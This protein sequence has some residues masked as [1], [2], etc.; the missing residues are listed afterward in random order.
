M[1]INGLNVKKCMF[2]GEQVWPTAYVGVLYG[3]FVTASTYS[4]TTVPAAGGYADVTW[5]LRIER[6]DGTVVDTVD[7]TSSVSVTI[8]DT[9]NFS[10][11]YN[12]TRQKYEWKANDRGSNGYGTSGSAIPQSADAR[13]CTI[14]ASITNYQYNNV[15]VSAAT[16]PQNPT[17]MRQNA[18]KVE[19]QSTYYGT[20]SITLDAYKTS[21]SAAPAYESSTYIHVTVNQYDRYQFYDDGNGSKVYGLRYTREILEAYKTNSFN[22]T[23]DSWVTISDKTTTRAKVTVSGRGHD[24]GDAR[25]STITATLSGTNVSNDINIYQQANKKSEKSRVL[26]SYSVLISKTAS[27]SGASSIANFAQGG[28]YIY[29]VGGQATYTITYEWPSRDADTT[30]PLTASQNPTSASTDPNVGSGNIDIANRRINI[31]AN[32]TDQ[33]KNYSV[34][35]KFTYGGVTKQSECT[36]NQAGIVYT[37]GTPQVSFGYDTI[38]ASGGNVFPTINFSQTRTWSGGTAT[39]VTGSLSGGATSGTA[40]DG[41][42]FSIKSIT[43][44]NVNPGSLR[45][46][47]GRVSIESRGTERQQNPTTRNAATNIKITITSHSNDGVNATGVS[48]VQAANTWQ[49]TAAYTTCS[50]LN[51]AFSPSTLDYAGSTVVG[52]LATAGGNDVTER[53][54]YASGEHEGGVST[55]YSGRSV[56]LK[57]LSVNGTSQSD[58]TKFTASNAQKLTTKRYTVSGTYGSNDKSASASITQAADYKSDYMY[59]DYQVSFQTFSGSVSASGGTISVIAQG[60]CTRYRYWAN[61]EY[62]EVDVSANYA[63]TPTITLPDNPGTSIYWLTNQTTRSGV[64]GCTLNHRNMANNETT[65]SVTVTATAGD[66]IATRAVSATNSR[67]YG[68]IAIS[69]TSV[70]TVPAGGTTF[71]FTA[72]CPVTWTSGYPDPGLS[73]ADITFALTTKG[74]N[75][76]RDYTVTYNSSTGKEDVTFGSLGTNEVSSVK[77]SVL[78]ASHTGATSKT[79]TISEAKNEITLESLSVTWSVSGTPIEGSG[80]YATIRISSASILRTYD[81]G[82][83][84]TETVSG[85]TLLRSITSGSSWLTYRYTTGNDYGV[86]T[87]T[88]NP[89]TSQYR[90]AV[91]TATYNGMTAST[92]IRQSAASVTTMNIYKLEA[93]VLSAR[94]TIVSDIQYV[95][96]YQSSATSVSL[97]IYT[98]NEE[99]GT[100]TLLSTFTHSE[101]SISIPTTLTKW[102]NQ[103][104]GYFIDAA[105]RVTYKDYITAV[106]QYTVG[107]NTYTDSMSVLIDIPLE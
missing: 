55:P 31:P 30:E 4:L 64:A 83:E 36:V 39:P 52:I 5:T 105:A 6:P 82:A 26:S 86:A 45:T 14:N 27:G 95:S 96:T 106:L 66:A 24:N 48:V 50:T 22:F 65:D 7:V 2:R 90:D 60:K 74:N 29:F 34:Y 99:G 9:T 17:V 89:S 15:P 23:A 8:G 93:S 53:W 87:A 85:N 13:T 54:D 76:K 35:G 107:S 10:Y 102:V 70:G 18:N 78:T 51:I 47:D 49:Y 98:S 37:Y 61:S 62:A 19:Y 12:S 56:T 41:T 104:G 84:G 58:T 25:Y 69:P 75:G 3:T 71:S 1:R 68:S 42:T 28:G 94:L 46:S 79:I 44:T 43:G 92:T 32:Q 57:T 21:G 100:D 81:S 91:L 88:S 63:T 16:D 97:K 67:S 33:Q 77:S 20:P 101:S 72:S 80:G 38:P 103:H 40:S 73:T 59:R 11:A